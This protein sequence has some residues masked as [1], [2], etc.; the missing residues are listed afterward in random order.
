MELFGI[1]RSSG[2]AQM[3]HICFMF[4][5]DP[6]L[7]FFAEEH[8][9]VRYAAEYWPYHFRESSMDQSV[10]PGVLQLLQGQRSLLMNWSRFWVA[11]N[12]PGRVAIR[13]LPCWYSSSPVYFASCLGPHSVLRKLLDEPYM[14]HT[15]KPEE[16]D[17]FTTGGHSCIFKCSELASRRAISSPRPPNTSIGRSREIL[18]PTGKP[19]SRR[20]YTQRAVPAGETPLLDQ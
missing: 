19:L 15:S 20:S 18:L 13:E 17:A 7:A 3:A 6:E 10:D 14:N 5:P 8:L 12:R 2:D 4:L 9:F 16:R 11:A 1:K